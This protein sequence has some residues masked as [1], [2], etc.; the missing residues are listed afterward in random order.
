MPFPLA[1]PRVALSDRR[2]SLAP[3]YFLHAPAA[4]FERPKKLVT[5]SLCVPFVW[6]CTG[7]SA[8]LRWRIIGLTNEGRFQFV[9]KG[10]CHERLAEH[11]NLVRCERCP[12]GSDG[13]VYDCDFLLGR[14]RLGCLKCLSA[15]AILAA[16]DG[17]TH[18]THKSMLTSLLGPRRSAQHVVARFCGL[19]H[20]SV[21]P[22]ER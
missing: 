21:L 2:A 1:G 4:V 18:L 15:T 19:R 11:C 17:S 20:Y 7:C 9:T 22:L 13:D 5:P 3:A 8:P 10:D 12:S 14:I 16:G 6:K